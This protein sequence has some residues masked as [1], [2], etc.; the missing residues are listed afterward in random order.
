MQPPQP[1]PF[2]EMSTQRLEAFSDGVFAIVITL[3]VLDLKVPEVA[4]EMADRTL[5]PALA[6]LWPKLLSYTISFVVVGVYWVAH[7]YQFN[8]I[9]RVNRTLLWIN[10]AFLMAVSLIAFSA[11][12][13]GSYPQSR[14]ALGIYG[15]NLIVVNL[16]LTAMWTYGTRTLQLIDAPVPA[17]CQ[18]VVM[19]RNLLPPIIYLVAI[20]LVFV[21]PTISLALYCLVPIL[22]VLPSSFDRLWSLPLPFTREPRS[23]ASSKRTP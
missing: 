4:V 6:H 20:A 2:Q 12:M 19:R 15:A 16:V 7:H 3:L 1:P 13:L 5:L 18:H 9:Q 23:D 11:A 10:L 8:T 14:A 17:S 22:Y 21:A